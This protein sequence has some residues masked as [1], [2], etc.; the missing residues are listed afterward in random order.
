MSSVLERLRKRSKREVTCNGETF[1]LRSMTT[2]EVRSSESVTDPTEKADFILG[3]T[4]CEADGSRVFVWQD[5]EAPATF[6]KRMSVELADVEESTK[7]ALL[8]ELNK[9]SKVP[10]AET[11]AKN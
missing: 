2:A 6:A 10:S 11:M 5:G 1:Y 3:T 4:L 7:I 9:A 8:T